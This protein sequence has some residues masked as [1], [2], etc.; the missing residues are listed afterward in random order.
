MDL[1]GNGH[2][3]PRSITANNETMTLSTKVVS[4]NAQLAQT[5]IISGGDSN[6]KV[7][8]TFCSTEKNQNIVCVKLSQALEAIDSEIEA[9]QYNNEYLFEN[10]TTLKQL[11]TL[12]E[13]KNEMAIILLSKIYYRI[14]RDQLTYCKIAKTGDI[15]Y[16]LAHLVYEIIVKIPK[17]NITFDLGNSLMKFTFYINTVFKS[18]LYLYQKL[19]LDSKFENYPY[20]IFGQN[21]ITYVLKKNFKALPQILTVSQYKDIIEHASSIQE[22]FHLIQTFDFYNIKVKEPSTSDDAFEL[23][24]LYLKFLFSSSFKITFNEQDLKNPE[25]INITLIVDGNQKFID[26]NVTGQS[27]SNV[28]HNLLEN[29]TYFIEKDIQNIQMLRNKKNDF[30][31]FDLSLDFIKANISKFKKDAKVQSTFFFLLRQIYFKDAFL[32]NDKL[33]IEDLIKQNNLNLNKMDPSKKSKVTIESN[34]LF[35]LIQSNLPENKGKDEKV[36]ITDLSINIGFPNQ[37]RVPSADK[38]FFIIDVKNPLT[39]IFLAFKVDY[40]DIGFI[41]EKFDE[42]TQQFKQI[43]FLEKVFCESVYHKTLLFAQE[44]GLYKITFNNYYSWYNQK[45]VD[46]YSIILSS[47]ENIEGNKEPKIE[48]NPEDKKIFFNFNNKKYTFNISRIKKYCDALFGLPSPAL[49]EGNLKEEEILDTNA[50]KKVALK[51]SCLVDIDSNIY[52]SLLIS[53][54]II[55][56]VKLGQ[57]KEEESKV[58]EYEEKVDENS[59]IK[60]GSNEE[61]QRVTQ[62]YF[63]NIIYELLQN[64]SSG[65]EELKDKNGTKINISVFSLN[66][67]L[68]TKNKAVAKTLKS[69]SSNAL[70]FSVNQE[71]ANSIKKIGLYPSTLISLYPNINYNCFDISEQCLLYHLYSE[72]LKEKIDIKNAMCL[73]FFDKYQSQIA[74]FSNGSIVKSYQNISFDKNKNLNDSIKEII[75]FV[76][77]FNESLETVDLIFCYS[78]RDENE[79][80]NFYNE[81]RNAVSNSDPVINVVGYGKNF[82]YDVFKFSFAFFKPENY[83]LFKGKE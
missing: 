3:D 22:Q 74:L 8:I 25:N 56:I 53:E 78:E 65:N 18:S 24:Q 57:G 26:Q 76:E 39:L 62:E 40:K 23:G 82:L 36:S 66:N 41:V 61:S 44:K 80:T 43:F 2:S 77:T 10:N 4:E 50:E 58:I 7:L 12:G 31:I 38:Y 45:I 37:V 49:K 60:D 83:E 71:M 63:E 73:I 34:E 69:I 47:S 42:P 55:R 79:M 52:F 59:K 9:L 32:N 17:S 64:Y 29:K 20:A 14:L 28:G 16:L 70:S 81:M 1:S 48:S 72:T 35:Q 68:Q 46:Y 5:K 33:V 15:Y 75:K 19:K 67:M 21:Y 11:E 30:L 51:G 6:F 54:N 27:F 13:I